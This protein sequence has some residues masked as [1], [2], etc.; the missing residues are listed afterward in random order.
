MLLGELVAVALAG[1]TLGLPGV[2]LE[3][4]RGEPFRLDDK[5][6]KSAGF[7]E[8]WSLVVSTRAGEMRADIGRPGPRL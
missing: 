2:G 6:R 1:Q 8:C 7:R 3:L 4:G 5:A